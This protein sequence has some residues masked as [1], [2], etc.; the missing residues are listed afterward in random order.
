MYPTNPTNT[1]MYSFMFEYIYFSKTANTAIRPI[2]AMIIDA[3]AKAAI[4]LNF[5]IF[6]PP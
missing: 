6:L 5:F 3:T 1:A 4:M 2:K